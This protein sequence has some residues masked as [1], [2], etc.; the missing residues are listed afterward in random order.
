[1]IARRPLKQSVESDTGSVIVADE[2]DA[3]SVDNDNEVRAGEETFD[4]HDLLLDE[5]D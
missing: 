1:M 3:S 2:D 4:I 5:A